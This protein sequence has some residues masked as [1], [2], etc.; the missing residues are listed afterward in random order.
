MGAGQHVLAD[1]ASTG[2]SRGQ[3][4]AQALAE[5]AQE[6]GRSGAEILTAVHTRRLLPA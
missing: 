2:Q 3:G 5:A 6:L 1:G 4:A